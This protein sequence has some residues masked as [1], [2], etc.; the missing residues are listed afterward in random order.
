MVLPTRSSLV[1]VAIGSSTRRT[2]CRANDCYIRNNRCMNFIVTMREHI[3]SA[4]TEIAL[5]W[6]PFLSGRAQNKNQDSRSRRKINDV[7]MYKHITFMRLICGVYALSSRSSSYFS[8]I[9]ET[10]LR[11]LVR[12]WHLDNLNNLIQLRN[13]IVNVIF[14][15]FICLCAGPILFYA[16]L[17]YAMLVLQR[18]GLFAFSSVCF[19]L[20]GQALCARCRA[21]WASVCSNEMRCNN[22]LLIFLYDFFSYKAHTRT[23]RKNYVHQPRFRN[24]E[25]EWCD[26]HCLDTAFS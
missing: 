25:N 22:L 17:C 5:N 4:Y 3:M 11:T 12:A 13:R 15:L 9:S 2:H 24:N 26:L 21:I 19:G 20:V 23:H 8:E 14:A 1:L 6:G 7:E 10:N 18:N 16:V